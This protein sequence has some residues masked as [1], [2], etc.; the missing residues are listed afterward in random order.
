VDAKGE[1]AVAVRTMTRRRG[2][3]VSNS[4]TWR[5]EAPRSVPAAMAADT[6]GPRPRHPPPRRPSPPRPHD[7]TSTTHYVWPSRKRAKPQPHHNVLLG[8]QAEQ[9]DLQEAMMT[10]MAAMMDRMEA[11]MNPVLAHNMA[12]EHVAPRPGL[13]LVTNTLDA[14]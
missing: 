4:R 3:S 12:A 10:G 14:V 13:H 2:H 8:Y 6:A 7:L 5:R 1:S 11:V 9:V